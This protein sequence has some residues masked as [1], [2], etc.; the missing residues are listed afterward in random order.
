[1]KSDKDIVDQVFKVLNKDYEWTKKR[2][3]D[4]LRKQKLV[5]L[6]DLQQELEE[7]YLELKEEKKKTK[8]TIEVSDD[9]SGETDKEEEEKGLLATH[10][11][12]A[13]KKGQVFRDPDQPN[14]LYLAIDSNNLSKGFNPYA[15]PT[16]FKGLCHAC[17]EWGHRRG[18]C[19]KNKQRENQVQTQTAPMQTTKT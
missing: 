11:S 17:G 14:L 10:L 19:P 15:F 16:Q 7:A 3:K 12:A 2:V 18:E 5:D 4:Q 13:S 1:M 8:K 6:T 9:S